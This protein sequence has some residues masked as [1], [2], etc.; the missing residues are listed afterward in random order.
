AARS[1]ST[2]RC[3]ERPDSRRPSAHSQCPASPYTRKYRS[4]AGRPRLWGSEAHLVDARQHVAF[5]EDAAMIDKSEFARIRRLL[6]F[7]ADHLEVGGGIDPG[8]DY[9]GHDQVD[10]FG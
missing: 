1:S 8:A 6:I 9:G 7:V 5:R 3:A 4:S 2:S 10:L